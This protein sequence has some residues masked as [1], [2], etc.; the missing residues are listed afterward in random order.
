[1]K[2]SLCL[3]TWNEVKGCQH[4]VPL[5][6]R[7]HF[8]EIYAI[9]GGSTD[10]TVEY[11]QSQGIPVYRQDKPGYNNAY[12]SAFRRCSTDAL[13]MYHPKGTVDPQVTLEFRRFLEDGYDLVIASRN[14]AGAANEEDIRIFKPRKWFVTG[15]AL[16]AGVLWKREGSMIWDVLHGCRAMRKD[17]FFAI[18]PLQDC[19]SI[20]IEMVIRA[21]RKRLR[22]I[23]FPVHEKPRLHGETHF[24]AF[25]TGLLVLR[26]LVQELGRKA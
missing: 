21:Y 22:R 24:K 26:Y 6:S 18:E 1:M 16:T 17:A 25:P 12:L 11:L 7:E 13:I 20:D 23:E 9:D 14:I 19:L 5:I 15:L 3:L 4:D 8:D 10:G 2:L